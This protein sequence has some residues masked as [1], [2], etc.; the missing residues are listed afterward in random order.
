MIIEV[1][2]GLKTNKVDKTFS[3][4]VPADLKAKIKPGIRVLVP[5]GKQKLEGFVIKTNK[6]KI[7]YKTK[8]IIEVIDEDVVL[9]D[10]MLDLGHYIKE[11]TLAPLISCYQ[12]ML[13]TALKV[14]TKNINK[15]YESYLIIKNNNQLNNEKQKIIVDLIIEKGRL[16]KSE[17]N[18]ISASAVKTLL[19]NNVI[20]E[21]KEEV[22]RLNN[23]D[24]SKGPSLKLTDEQERIVKTIC[25]NRN[26]F[27]PYLLHGVTGS[28]KTE[29]YMNIIDDVL[30][31]GKEA[32]VLEPEI[33]LTPQIVDK[34]KKRFGNKIAVLHS[35]L[36]NG[37]KYDEWRKIA[38]GEVSIVIGARSAVFAPFKNIGII[39]IDEE[40]SQTYKQENT[41]KYN[42]IDIAL[43]RGQKHKCNVLLGSATPSI[44]SYTRAKMKIYELLE[45][46]SRVNTSMPIVKLVDMQQELKKGNKILSDQLNETI[47]KTLDS[48]EQVILFLNRRGYST[49][50]TCH[51]CGYT[52]KC[53]HCDIPLTYHKNTGIMRC[54]YCG[55]AHPKLN[56]CPECHSKDINEFGLGIQK[57]EEEINRTFIDAKVVRMDIDSTSKK[58]SHEKIIKDFQNKKY[59]I[60]IGTQMIAKG[61]DFDNVTLV[62]V[63]NGDASLNIPD[64]RSGERTYQLLNQVSGR[65]G[66]SNKNGQVIIQAYNL[67]HYSILNAA[68]NDYLSFYNE[69]MRLRKMLKYPPFYNLTLI[70]I[71][72][73][74]YNKVWEESNKIAKYFTKKLDKTIDILGPNHPSIPKINDVYFV[75]IVLK[76]RNSSNVMGSL[77]EILDIYKINNKVNVEIDLNPYRI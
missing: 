20:N 43:Y 51:D 30:K 26:T 19:K 73:K 55:Y 61:L 71:S 60:L 52:D 31:Q 53:P 11:K 24:F 28:G 40:H 34:F 46:R 27:K 22:Y 15:K 9:T 18:K 56:I 75:Q 44:E 66:R 50:I 38:R 25:N 64:F 16:L 42:A 1:L 2:V 14:S 62:G 58:G 36:S 67:D 70:K 35:R 65:A 45:L 17:A 69:E 37:E 74:D 6:E 57:L 29:V 23:D 48:N 59:N 8:D 5:F 13:P 54:H 10:E 4:S 49:V 76:Y 7:D 41:P 63:I 72:S 33:S 32:I 39:I 77:K 12:A 47:R 3:Y 21:I 68:K